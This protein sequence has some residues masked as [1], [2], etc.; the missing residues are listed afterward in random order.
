[1]PGI[2]TLTSL[3]AALALTAC[4]TAPA[5]KQAPVQH[6]PAD[7]FA[8][9]KPDQISSSSDNKLGEL[10]SVP[11]AKASSEPDPQPGTPDPIER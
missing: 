5:Q 6:A 10:R 7:A 2:R 3:V 9:R 1:M 4:A 8:M 11:A